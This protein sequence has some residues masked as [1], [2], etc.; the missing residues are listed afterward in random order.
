MKSIKRHV[1]KAITWRIIGTLDT[2][3]LGFLLTGDMKIGLKIGAAEM[4][5]K[6]VL[7]FIH[8][9]IWFNIHVF[10]ANSSRTRHVLKTITWRF[11]G[12]IDTIIIGWLISGQAEVGLSIGGLEL[13][14]KMILYYLHERLW[15]KTKFGIETGK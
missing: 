8:E 10:K 1:A 3:L 11:L 4:A 2:I 15:Y 14:T 6:M 7:Y 12:S 9:R 13:G 5:T